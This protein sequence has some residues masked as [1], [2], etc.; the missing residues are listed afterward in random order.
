ML[1]QKLQHLP[2]HAHAQ[3]DHPV[4]QHQEGH[5]PRG[6][7]DRPTLS[8]LFDQEGEGWEFFRYECVN[9]KTSMGIIRGSVSSLVW[10]P[11]GRA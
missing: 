3:T 6:K 11:G 10:V 1:N 7:V 8:P 5:T 4:Q 9:Y 2:I